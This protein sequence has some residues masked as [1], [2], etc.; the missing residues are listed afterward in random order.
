MTVRQLLSHQAGLVTVDGG[1]GGD[2]LLAHDPLAARLAA[3]R[4][5]WFPGAACGYH[6]VTLG[7][8][9]DELVRRVTGRTL[10]EVFRADVASPRGVDVHLGVP[11]SLDDRVAAVDLPTRAELDAGLAGTILPSP[12]SLGALSAPRLDVPF[13]LWANT[14]EVRRVG[15]PA[16]GAL[17][18]ARGLARMYASVHHDLGG[19]R[20][21]DDDTV[22]QVAQIQAQGIDVTSGEPCRFGVVFQRPVAPRLLFGSDW[23]YGHDGLGGSVGFSDPLH[24]LAVGYVVKR[25]PLPGG[26]DRR[27]VDLA[28][29]LRRCAAAVAA[30]TA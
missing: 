3:Q 28:R 7:T 30:A 10:A 6:G 27:A 22:A 1:Y 15:P 20:L 16:A 26:I 11:P 12:G 4:P 24:D 17:A 9:A 19:G 25:I 13:W 18:T 23:A 29:D 5:H 14:E 8:L 2:E 21:L